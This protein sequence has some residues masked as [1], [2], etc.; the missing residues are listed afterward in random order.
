MFQPAEPLSIHPQSS[1]KH[2]EKKPYKPKP[3]EIFKMKKR[4]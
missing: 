4:K 2:Q 1:E 3:R